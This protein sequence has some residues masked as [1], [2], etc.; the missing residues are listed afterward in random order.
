MGLSQSEIEQYNFP[1]TIHLRN[2]GADMK[3]NW[4]ME[5]LKEKANKNWELH[6]FFIFFSRVSLHKVHTQEARDSSQNRN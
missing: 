2:Q 5:I 4:E 1:V 6:V 3:I